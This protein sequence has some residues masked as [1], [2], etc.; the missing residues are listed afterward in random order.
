MLF[1]AE[2]TKTLS[3]LYH[4]NAMLIQLFNVLKQKIKVKIQER[5]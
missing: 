5:R 1:C 3:T 2:F 4:V